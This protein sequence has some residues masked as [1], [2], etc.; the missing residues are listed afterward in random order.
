MYENVHKYARFHAESYV[1]QLLQFSWSIIS[2]YNKITQSC[3]WNHPVYWMYAGMMYIV[4]A[5]L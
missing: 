4:H 3:G 2:N 1:Q 5:T